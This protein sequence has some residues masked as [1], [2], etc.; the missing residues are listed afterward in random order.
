LDSEFAI[1]L[2]A[3]ADVKS[4]AV[5]PDGKIVLGGSFTQVDGAARYRVAR[6]LASGAV[7][8]SFAPTIDPAFRVL[9][10]FVGDLGRIYAGGAMPRGNGYY[11]GQVIR[12]HGDVFGAHPTVTNGSFIMQTMA[13]DGW[14]YHLE[15]TPSSQPFVWTNVVTVIGDGTPQT[16][17]DPAP[18]SGS[19]YRI[20]VD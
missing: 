15:R 2:G 14:S 7:D 4:I 17:V 19:F 16:L 12:L 1:G 9:T 5:Q 20:R 3:N 18:V 10:V 13:A 8:L 11:K 6:L